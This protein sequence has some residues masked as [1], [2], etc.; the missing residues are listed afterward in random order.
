MHLISGQ[1]IALNQIIQTSDVFTLRI[2][3]NATFEIDV[4]SFG[5]GVGDTLFNDDYMTFY[6]QP[7]TPAAEVRYQQQRN[8]HLFHFNLKHINHAQTPRFILCAAVSDQQKNL[9]DVKA[10]QIELLNSSGQVVATYAL[11]PSY[12]SQEKAAMLVEVYF[13]NDLWCL[14]AI[15]QGFNSGLN[16]L[17]RHFGAEVA[18][19]LAPPMPTLSKL[20]LK[21]K[22]IL[23]KIEQAAPHLLD[24][25]KKSLI[26]LEK[27][28]L[29]NIK[30]RV[31]LVLDYS[32]SM[33]QQYKS[34][35][36]QQVLDRIIPLAL[37]FDDDGSFECWAF[38]EK[39]LHLNDVN[40]ENLN[41]YIASEQGGYKKWNAGAGYNNEPAVLEEVLHY[42][43][44]E[45]PSNVAVYI[46]FI[47]DGGVSE[48]RKIKKILQE[49]SSQPI[50]WQFV[51]IGG[52]NYGVLEKLDTM[53]GR[54]V[55]NCNFF[56]IDNIESISESML[57]DFLLQEFPIWLTEAKNK[58]IVRG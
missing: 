9:R 53:E 49:A 6:N 3:M 28:N 23:D 32:G 45:S 7:Q 52:R 46:V 43:I 12:F 51:G 36:V 29:L 5:L 27:S 20:D 48:A 47:S 4:S 31:A 21:K 11:S 55:D 14:A 13:K 56:K 33:S 22:V 18:E 35:E 34:G 37:N 19:D 44:K 2:Q 41:N 30:A 25:T 40:L 50:F 15:G 16:A 57:Y 38:A 1:K 24:L 10:I 8:A 26:S 42:F 39:A 58:N 54:V 17:V